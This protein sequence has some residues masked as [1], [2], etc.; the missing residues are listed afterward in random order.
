MFGLEHD[1]G[2][3]GH[4]ALAL[5]YK[6]REEL[7]TQLETRELRLYFS[8]L[9]RLSCGKSRCT[10]FFVS[11]KS[12]KLPGKSTFKKVRFCCV[13]VSPLHGSFGPYFG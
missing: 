4:C 5:G 2:E 7:K 13:S 6:P 9:N 1:T 11:R 12:Y 8:V 10:R 3:H